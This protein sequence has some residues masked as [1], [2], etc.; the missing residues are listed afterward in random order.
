M[1]SHQVLVHFPLLLAYLGSFYIGTCRVTSLR[2]TNRFDDLVYD[3]AK[4]D[5]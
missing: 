5:S 2:H 3:R 4:H 1:Y